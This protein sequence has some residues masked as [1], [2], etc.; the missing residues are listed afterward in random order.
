MSNDKAKLA[1]TV[2]FSFTASWESGPLKI[3][4]GTVK[5]VMDFI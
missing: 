2:V 5:A 1:D 4:A 3:L